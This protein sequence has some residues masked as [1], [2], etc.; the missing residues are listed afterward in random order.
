MSEKACEH[1]KFYDAV[2]DSLGTCHRHAPS[3]IELLTVKTYSAVCL[4]AWWVIENGDGDPDEQLKAFGLDP[5]GS[6]QDERAFWPMVEPLEWCG[7]FQE[8][9]A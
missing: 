7:E 4:I 5:E 1:C 2:T 9:A 8:R 3:P 6:M